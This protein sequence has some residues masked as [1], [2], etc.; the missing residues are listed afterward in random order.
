MTRA[1]GPLAGKVALVTGATRGLG[2]EIAMAFAAAGADLIATSRHQDACDELAVELEALGATVLARACHVG[3]WGE[4]DDLVEAAYDRFGRID[5]LVNNAGMSPLYGR[6][7]EISEELWNKVIGVNLMGPFRLSALIG[8]RM[9]DAGSGSIVN[10]GSTAGVRPRKDIIPYAAAKAGLN[11]ITRGF[12]DSLGP[13][14]RV[15]ALIVGPFLT[16]VS[17]A[18]DMDKVNARV[19]RYPLGRAGSPSEIV[20]AAMFLASD[21]SSF[22]TGALLPVDGGASWGGA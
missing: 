17:G 5:V 12:A 16:D 21:A 4:V 14:V 10:I 11:A 2:R 13:T 19:S 3:H 9:V 8:T 20:G 7:D 1:D 6:V 15:N 18:W 22:T